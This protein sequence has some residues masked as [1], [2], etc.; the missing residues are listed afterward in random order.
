MAPHWK[1]ILQPALAAGCVVLAGCDASG[2]TSGSPGGGPTPQPRGDVVLKHDGLDVGTNGLEIGFE[3]TQASTVASVG[4]LLGRGPEQTTRRADCAAGPVTSAVWPGGLTLT[5][6]SGDFRGWVSR[7][8]AL[9]TASGLRVGTDRT[10]VAALPA[11]RF[12]QGAQGEEFS[13]GGIRGV[14]AA[15]GRVGA[16]WAGT[17]CL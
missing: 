6:Q 4:K 3:R 14:I 5:F 7:D 2:P 17:T 8:S 13:V 10:S 15:D 12:S 16:L 9:R 1:Q 11:V